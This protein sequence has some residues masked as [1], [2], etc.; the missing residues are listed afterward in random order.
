M[1]VISLNIDSSYQLQADVPTDDGISKGAFIHFSEQTMGANLS[2]TTPWIAFVS[3]DQNETGASQEWDIFTL[4]RDRGAVAAVSDSAVA[5][6]TLQLLFSSTAESCL[7]NAEYIRDF[8]KP[9]DVFATTS[10]GSARYAVLS[11]TTDTVES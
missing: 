9:L 8:E 10:Q 4:A 1:A 6:L 7:L 5:K 11:S 2:T 3:C